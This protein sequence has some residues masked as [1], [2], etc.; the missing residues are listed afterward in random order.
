MIILILRIN[1]GK[2]GFI[3]ADLEPVTELPPLEIFTCVCVCFVS[4]TN[5]YSFLK[6]F[7]RGNIIKPIEGV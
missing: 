1:L 2:S 7:D 5:N 3:E 4:S 6:T